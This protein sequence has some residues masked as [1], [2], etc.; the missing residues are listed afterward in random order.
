M[1]PLYSLKTKWELPIP[2]L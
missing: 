1:V 2:C